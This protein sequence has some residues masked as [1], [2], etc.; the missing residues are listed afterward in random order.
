[1]SALNILGRAFGLPAPA[2]P[3]YSP[4]PALRQLREAM[5][6]LQRERDQALHDKEDAA[7]LFE[8]AIASCPIPMVVI[9]SVEGDPLFVN[10]A[11]EANFGYSLTDLRCGAWRTMIASEERTQVREKFNAAAARGEKIVL[12]YQAVTK[13]GDV[14]PVEAEA[15]PIRRGHRVLG[16]VV[17]LV[18]WKAA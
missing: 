18:L 17:R 11:F 3:P 8:G 15:V 5:A 6:R 13:G 1:M 12:R 14:V 4:S 7:A 10:G 2:A 16:Y 9:K